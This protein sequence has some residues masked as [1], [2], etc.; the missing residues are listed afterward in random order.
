MHSLILIVEARHRQHID[1]AH[2]DE[3]CPLCE[4]PRGYSDSFGQW[5]ADLR[6]I[7]KPVGRVADD[8]T[9]VIGDTPDRR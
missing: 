7:L 5:V 8:W 3:S 1:P 9:T 2:P 4:H 6:S